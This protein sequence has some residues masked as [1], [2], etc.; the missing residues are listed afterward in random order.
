MNIGVNSTPFEITCHW[1]DVCLDR[2]RVLGYRDGKEISW[3]SMPGESV[4]AR[5]NPGD[6]ARISHEI[7]IRDGL[8]VKLHQATGDFCK[9]RSTADVKYVGMRQAMY[10][11][12]A[13]EVWRDTHLWLFRFGL[14]FTVFHEVGHLNQQHGLFRRKLGLRAG[15]HSLDDDAHFEYAD[16]DAEL[17]GEE[18][19]LAQ[20]LERCADFEGVKRTMDV[21][22]AMSST[23]DGKPQDRE[24][25]TRMVWLALVGMCIF[26][27]LLHEER[28]SRQL[29]PL[30]GG[31][32]R[33]SARM[34]EIVRDT[35]QY[36]LRYP[37]FFPLS[38]D[39][40]ACLDF[41]EEAVITAS[42]FWHS[43]SSSPEIPTVH[44][45]M[46]DSA[47]Y[48]RWRESIRTKWNEIVPVLNA[49][50]ICKGA[51]LPELPSAA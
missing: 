25:T 14:S 31:H 36:I 46:Q 47:D 28:G 10:A 21:I 9:T 29:Y 5:A 39:P 50:R 2:M 49:Q 33:P 32:P 41:L 13:K 27:Y 48:L 16:G 44:A 34:L 22:R 43:R 30:L 38:E 20:T 19:L 18:A 26:C 42:Q 12:F 35:H 1:I 23:P 24:Q 51:E 11:L 6:I 15:N 40:D 7:G 3:V 17:T 4:N 37:D 45:E 8:I